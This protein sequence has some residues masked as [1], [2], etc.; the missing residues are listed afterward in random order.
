M[1]YGISH[2]ST[3]MYDYD[4]AIIELQPYCSSSNNEFIPLYALKNGIYFSDNQ[5]QEVMYYPFKPYS[6]DIPTLNTKKPTALLTYF[7][8]GGPYT[9]MTNNVVYNVNKHL[10]FIVNDLEATLLC[11]S[12][13]PKKYFFEV[14]KMVSIY[15]DY[16]VNTQ[17]DYSK[18]IFV[19]NSQLNNSEHSGVKRRIINYLKKE[20]SECDII[21]TSNV[22]NWGFNNKI[23]NPTFTNVTERINYLNSLKTSL[24]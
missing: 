12:V 15:S 7:K 8:E 21:Y 10:L 20:Y 1:R 3:R 6:H 24:L 22:E 5:R 9:I 16:H 11:Y 19:L 14:A 18:L 13:L 4:V 2:C 23:N 17:F